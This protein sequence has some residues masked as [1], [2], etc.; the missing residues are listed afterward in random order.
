MALGTELPR[1]DSDAKNAKGLTALEIG[2]GAA[3]AAVL[4]VLAWWLR[5]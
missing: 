5:R 3:F 4:M 1:S 2:G